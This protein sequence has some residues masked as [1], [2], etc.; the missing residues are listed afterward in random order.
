[1]IV[2]KPRMLPGSDKCFNLRGFGHPVLISG[3][4]LI[5]CRQE[6]EAFVT[7]FTYL[8]SDFLIRG[9]NVPFQELYLIHGRFAG[10]SNLCLI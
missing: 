9:Q 6:D 7:V 4:W 10:K 8:I 3:S 5:K 1:M 2:K